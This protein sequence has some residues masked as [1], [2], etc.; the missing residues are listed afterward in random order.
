MTLSTLGATILVWKRPK[1]GGWIFVLLGLMF[2]LLV[3]R[4]QSWYGIII[5]GVLLLTGILFLAE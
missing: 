1:L 3:F 5:G 2:F 4:Q